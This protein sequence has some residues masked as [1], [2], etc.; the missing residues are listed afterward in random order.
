MPQGFVIALGVFAP[1]CEFGHILL[2]LC[3]F[4]AL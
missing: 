3:L 1:A 2:I 4:C